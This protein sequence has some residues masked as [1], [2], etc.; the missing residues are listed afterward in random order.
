M[1]VSA[2]FERRLLAGIVDF[3]ITLAITLMIFLF[4]FPLSFGSI[5]T[6]WSLLGEPLSLVLFGLLSAVSVIYFTFFEAL[7]GQTPGKKAVAIRVVGDDS[8]ECS[9]GRILL[10]NVVRIIDFL[11]A[12]YILGLISIMVTNNRKRFGDIL[13]RTSVVKS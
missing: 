7:T 13:A 6:P 11:P 10:R 8:P 5:S 12:F 1:R 9:V 4:I 2:G 3:V